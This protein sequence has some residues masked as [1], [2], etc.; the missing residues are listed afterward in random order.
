VVD[1]PLQ[2]S[3][4]AALTGFLSERDAA[5]PVCSYNLRG[6]RSVFCPECGARLHLQVGSENLRL[7]PWFVSCISCAL[8]LGFDGVVATVMTVMLIRHPPPSRGTLLPVLGVYACF[9]TLAAA[10]GTG[11][12]W[13]FKRRAKFLRQD[14]PRQWRVAWSIFGAV[15][16]V[17][18]IFGGVLLSHM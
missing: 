15:L 2:N 13:L 9:L 3:D 6:L 5:C 17:H 18:A 8:A 14:R 12:A 11:L 4:L 1:Q 16:V 7:G 10:S